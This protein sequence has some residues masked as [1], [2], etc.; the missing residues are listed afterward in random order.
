[1]EPS[2]A[3]PFRELRECRPAGVT[4]AKQFCGLVECLSGRVI[5]RFTEEL[6][7][8]YAGHADEFGMPT[9]CEKRDE[10]EARRR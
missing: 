9:R 8:P 10:R 7:A 3:P 2:R 1:M 5:N 6:V 4:Q